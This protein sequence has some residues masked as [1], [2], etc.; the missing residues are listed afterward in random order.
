MEQTENIEPQAAT[1]EPASL[2]TNSQALARTSDQ[3]SESLIE[4]ALDAGRDSRPDRASR[5]D[6]WTPERIR[7]FLEVLAQCGVVSDAARAAGKTARSAY[8]LRNS[9]KGR[10][11]DVAWR[12][13]LLQARRLLA[14]EIMSRA[15]NGCVEVIVRD[16]EV[17]GERH[18]Y[19]NR[20][21]MAVLTR[22]DALAKEDH[23]H[24]MVPA[25]LANAFEE[26]VDIVCA[27]GEGAAE[28]IRARC[29]KLYYS[30]VDEAGILD[31]AQDYLRRR[32]HQEAG[33]ERHEWQPGSL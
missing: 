9:A 30:H 10:A 26:F 28:F 18:R 2:S 7:T 4:Q 5:A 29:S 8:N 19:D 25:V 12:A 15:L 23:L 33:D 14:D 11:F 27:G 3:L 20:L 32:A 31:R 6:G 24:D 22:L 13:A 16:G 21:S 17:W 1:H